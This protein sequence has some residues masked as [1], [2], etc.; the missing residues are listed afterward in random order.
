MWVVRHRVIY[1]GSGDQMGYLDSGLDNEIID[2]FNVTVYVVKH[3]DGTLKHLS[4]TKAE[5][6]SYMDGLVETEPDFDAYYGSSLK[7]SRPLRGQTLTVAD[8]LNQAN[9]K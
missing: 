1:G 3:D 5:M 6:F 8:I 9:R 4:L 7:L 2:E